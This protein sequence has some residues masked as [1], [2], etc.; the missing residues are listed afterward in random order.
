MKPSKWIIS[1]AM[2]IAMALYLIFM[3]SYIMGQL[4]ENPYHD[5][6]QKEGEPFTGI[7]SVWHI[8]GF[9]P[10]VGSLGN[11]LTSCTKEFE[12]KHFGVFIEVTAM[13][14]AEY[15]ERVLRGE[16]ADVYSFPKGLMSEWS[17]RMADYEEAAYLG[18]L[19][20]EGVRGNKRYAMPF[21]MS[22]YMLACNTRLLQERGV[23]VDMIDAD[24]LN[25][26][27][28]ACTYVSGKRN[29]YGLSGNQEVASML[30]FEGEAAPYENF[31]NERAAMAI[32]DAY[33][34][35][36][37]T[38]NQIA[39]KGFTFEAYPLTNYTDLVQSI[40]MANNIEEEKMPYAM[41]F[42]ASLLKEETQKKLTTLGL[43]PVIEAEGLEFTERD[44]EALYQSLLDPVLR[45]VDEG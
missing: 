2:A 12:A 8:V 44:M 20:E 26:A 43:M 1:I 23:K 22:G 27:A 42:I 30:G 29:Y 39:G 34:I 35:G 31:T 37:L 18:E 13:T 14:M 17:L 7:I 6:L 36:A 15:E 5:W 4:R 10:Y 25:E 28:Q 38:R 11:F 16:S 45:V 41:E 19:K 32:V 24:W 33:G 9:R 40:G 21:A 3:P